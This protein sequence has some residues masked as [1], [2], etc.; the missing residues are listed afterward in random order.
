MMVEIAHYLNK[1]GQRQSGQSINRGC[2]RLAVYRDFLLCRDE[3][4]WLWEERGGSSVLS[5]D[6]P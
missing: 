4:W 3:D 1:K 6:T 5:T 2:E